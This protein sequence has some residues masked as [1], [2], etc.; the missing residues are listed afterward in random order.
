MAAASPSDPDAA[1]AASA[2]APTSTLGGGGGAGGL[3]VVATSREEDNIWPALQPTAALSSL[4]NS[5]TRE[6]AGYDFADAAAAGEAAAT[7]LS[8]GGDTQAFHS[9]GSSHSELATAEAALPFAPLHGGNVSNGMYVE[10]RV[11]HAVGLAFERLWRDR[12]AGL[13]EQEEPETQQACTVDG[14]IAQYFRHVAELSRE[15][16]Y[17][18]HQREILE[19]MREDLVAGDRSGSIKELEE[20]IQKVDVDDRTLQAEIASLMRIA[21]QGACGGR[22]PVQLG[23]C[24]CCPGGD[25][26]PPA[27]PER[28]QAPLM[29]TGGEVADANAAGAPAAA[30]GGAAAADGGGRSVPPCSAC[31]VQ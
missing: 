21:G 12:T 1:A 23:S 25:D 4:L 27:A 7:A 10:D 2:P 17:Q 15:S 30:G 22:N 24:V 5:G 26:Y 3:I 16:V 9:S 6:G 14:Y 13:P 19:R 8:P 29:L 18:A 11:D 20:M 31:T 28:L